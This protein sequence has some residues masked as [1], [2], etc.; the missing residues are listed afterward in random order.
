MYL[1]YIGDI[2]DGDSLINR[3]EKGGVDEVIIRREWDVF[4]VKAKVFIVLKK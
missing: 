1:V 4:V 3:Y 2:K